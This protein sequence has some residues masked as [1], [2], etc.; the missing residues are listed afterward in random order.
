M[1]LG[2][3]TLF[4]GKMGSGKSTKASELAAKTKAILLSEDELLSSLYPNLLSNLD[5]YVKYSCLLKPEIKKIAQAAL[6]AG[7]DVVMD[8]PANTARQ[9]K[10][11]QSVY[12]D[13]NAHHVMYVFDTPDAVCLK[14]IKER[15][16][17]QPERA[18]TD[19]AEMFHATS[20]FFS[21]PS[22]EEHFNTV[23]IKLD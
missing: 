6:S 14:R 4:C 22:F 1:T 12:I 7:C 23:A 21:K 15:A 3:L 8:F 11:L 5:D 19:T 13:I 20:E 18:N 16:K 10:W 17:A 9:R 2:T